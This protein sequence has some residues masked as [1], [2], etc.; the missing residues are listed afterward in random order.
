MRVLL[1]RMPMIMPAIVPMLM[2]I[3]IVRVRRTFMD[4]KFHAFQIMPLRPLEVHVE[5]AEV[6]LRELP[7]ERGWFHAEIDEC[8]D[9]H[10]AADA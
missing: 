8:A 5:I 2:F 1:V 10:V 7:F 9:R 4:A 6:E 3:L